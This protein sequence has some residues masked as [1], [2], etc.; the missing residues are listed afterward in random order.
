MHSG[1]SATSRKNSS[2]VDSELHDVHVLQ[3]RLQVVVERCR[4]F[5]RLPHLVEEVL[6]LRLELALQVVDLL[7]QALI[8]FEDLLLVR[9]ELLAPFP[10]GLDFVLVIFDSGLERLLL[11]LQGFQPFLDLLQPRF[12]AVVS[13]FGLDVRAER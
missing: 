9:Q 2:D 5:A 8:P 12:L 4:E 7:F 11:L 3:Q 6:R 10:Q 13:L 1:L